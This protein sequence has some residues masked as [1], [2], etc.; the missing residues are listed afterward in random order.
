MRG[1]IGRLGHVAWQRWGFAALFL[2][3][4]ISFAQTEPEEA[5]L[6]FKEACWFDDELS[7]ALIFVDAIEQPVVILPDFDAEFRFFSWTVETLQNDERGSYVALVE[8][9]PKRSGVR[10]FPPIRLDSDDRVW[11]TRPRQIVVGTAYASPEMSFQVH[12]PKTSVYRGEPIRL[13]FS[14]ECRLPLGQL[15]DFRLYPE[16]FNNASISIVVPRSVVAEEEQFG[17]PV[18][19]RRVIAHR[20]PTPLTEAGQMGGARFSIF[21]RFEEPG[22][23]E[24]PATRLLCTRMLNPN[25]QSNQ[26]AAYFNNGLFEAP[27]RSIPY[28]KIETHCESLR[29]EVAPLP[30]K[31]REESFSGLFAPEGIEVTTSPRELQVGQLM[32][33]R[34]DVKSATAS[35]MISLG[36]VDRQSSLRHRFWV[37]EEMN[38]LW[39]PDGRTFTVR[40]RPLTV[41][42]GFFPSLTFQTFNPEEGRYDTIRTGLIPLAVQPRDGKGYFNMGSIP[43]A[44]YNLAASSGGVWHNEKANTMDEAMN[45]VVALFADGL[46]II[47]MGG[48][49]AFAVLLPRVRELRR[50]ATDTEY[51]RRQ[52]AYRR[53]RKSIAGSEDEVEALRSLIADCYGRRDKALTARDARALLQRSQGEEDLIAAVEDALSQADQAPFRRDSERVALVSQVGALG[54]RVFALRNRV[55]LALIAVLGLSMGSD[56][57]SA[58][59]WKA[60][61]AAFAQ[62]L[63]TAESSSDSEAIEGRF[64]EAALK[65][66]ACGQAGVRPGIAWY[67][68]GNAWFKSG[69]LGRAIASYRQA[70]NYRPFDER[71]VESLEATRA[72]RIDALPEIDRDWEWPYR[73]RQ[74]LFSASWIALLSV[75][76]FWIRYRNRAWR[77][78]AIASLLWTILLGADLAKEAASDLSEGVLVVDEAYGRKGPSY[79]YAS[80]FIDPLHNGMELTILEERS[81][82]LRTRLEEGSECWLPKDT[83]QSIDG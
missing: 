13:D 70:R 9:M 8:F 50:R 7:T 65:F 75:A 78:A 52:L 69:E 48:A 47:A 58:A 56:A 35:E 32:E 30:Q 79:A 6:E 12:A 3:G 76:L 25:S 19:G 17:I 36:R 80:A 26:Y 10:N 44:V 63:E 42:A 15:R 4:G 31:G 55:A 61:E 60:A 5:R 43:G 72:L 38:E 21:I 82:W 77:L 22:V 66:E 40:A 39:R 59:D 20:R 62:A 24:L 68:A 37:G 14:W 49:V 71:L 27:D 41:E 57:L 73:W 11:V 46:W 54:K 81:G 53:F 18:G 67:N 64:A 16:F 34:I 74:A 45:S 2:G 28:E 29:F 1:L 23:Y 83:V 51:R 33:V